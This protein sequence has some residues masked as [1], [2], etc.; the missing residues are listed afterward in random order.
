MIRVRRGAASAALCALALSAP[1]ARAAGFSIFE[2][3]AKGMGFAGAFTAQANDPSAVFH[4]AAGI[5][6]IKGKQLYVGGVILNPTTDFTGAD[7]FPGEGRLESTTGG[8]IPVPNAYYTQALTDRLAVGVGLHV[9]FR[10]KT[11]WSSPETFTGRFI[12]TR[13]ELK[14]F[15]LNPVVA[16]KLA[17]RLSVG[18]GIDVRFYKVELDRSIGAVNPFSLKFTD[19]AQLQLTSD[20]AVDIG[21]NVGVLA[22]PSEQ[23]SLG[24]AYRHKVKQ[25]FSGNAGF[26]LLPTGNSQ[27]DAAVA[28]A[29]P[30]GAVPATTEIEFPGVASAGAAYAWN[31]WL[32]AA[33][34]DFFQWSSFDVLPLIL[35]GR[36]DLSSTTLE[37]Y[38]NSWQVRVGAER[39]LNDVWRVRGGYF[40]DKTPSPVESVS[41]ILPDASRHGI[42][43]G[44]SWQRDR[45]RVD[46]GGSYILFQS[47]S[48]EGRSRERFDGTYESHA[49]TLG[50]SVGYS[51]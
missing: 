4:N 30:Q 41:P 36:G 31:D 32:F 51:F 38:E 11:E 12:T 1:E 14:G 29:L 22:K 26:T 6:F 10:L 2:Q 46:A 39:R 24:L 50:V 25:S 33:D 37:R 43:V 44:G 45:L 21:F 15:A 27:F 3:G 48:T 34:L 13:A 28:A 5:A 19:V 8:V 7:P 9:P 17:D 49:L 47:R 35:E 16:Y 42:C 23:L 20:R 18:G 40:F